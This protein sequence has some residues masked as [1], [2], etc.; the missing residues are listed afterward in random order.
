MTSI[1]LIV[2][3]CI[4]V[5]SMGSGAFSG[6]LNKKRAKSVQTSY[7]TKG[8]TDE[9]KKV[10]KYFT[11]GGCISDRISDEKYEMLVA[12][13]LQAASN[14]EH[15]LE[16]LGL[17]ESQVQEIPP[18]CFHGYLFEDALERNHFYT[19]LLKKRGNDDEWRSS[20]YMVSWIFFGD[21][22]VY[23]YQEIFCMDSLDGRITTDEYFYD[24]IVNFYTVKDGKEELITTGC[25]G[26]G[27]RTQRVT[28]SFAIMV[29]GETKIV[30][31]N[32]SERNMAAIEGMKQKLREKKIQ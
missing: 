16:V 30:S 29:P 17:D 18:V 27:T 12:T 1:I 31:L 13:R 21:H 4:I 20:A 32:M 11:T 7:G 2:L 28:P 19:N 6:F 8:K 15:A 22:E 26:T 24:D 25:L 5:F 9:Q 10:I 14:K 23:F 3:A